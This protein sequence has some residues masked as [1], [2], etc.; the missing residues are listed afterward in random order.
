MGCCLTG[1]LPDRLTERPALRTPAPQPPHPPHPPTPPPTLIRQALRALAGQC[2]GALRSA[3]AGSR[4]RAVELAALE[5]EHGAIG[6]VVGG[7]GGLGSP[8]ND[9]HAKDEGA[10]AQPRGGHGRRGASEAAVAEASAAERLAEVVQAKAEALDEAL[11]QGG[12]LGFIA[13]QVGF[14]ALP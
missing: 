5:R 3:A 2:C 6:G 8:P 7:P 9:S 11:N 4:A 13:L 10:D 12:L 1:L 14:W